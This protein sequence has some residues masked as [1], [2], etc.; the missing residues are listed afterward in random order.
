MRLEV[1]VHYFFGQMCEEE[2]MEP[3]FCFS[4]D[5]PERFSGGSMS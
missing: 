3:F 1:S 4:K 5:A 2:E